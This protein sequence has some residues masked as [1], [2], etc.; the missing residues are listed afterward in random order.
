M[1]L[2]TS[3][4]IL[5]LIIAS[6][7]ALSLKQPSLSEL[8]ETSKEFAE[9]I[10]DKLHEKVDGMYNFSRQF[11]IVVRFKRNYERRV[12]QRKGSAQY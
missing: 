12:Q 1:K 9:N 3:L 4:V 7:A 10:K 8:K 2:N 11:Y 6:T 5:A